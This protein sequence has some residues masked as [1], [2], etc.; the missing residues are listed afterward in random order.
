MVTALNAYRNEYAKRIFHLKR[1]DFDR[2]EKLCDV[3]EGNSELVVRGVTG[4]ENNLL[5]V[6]ILLK[7]RDRLYFIQSTTFAEGRK[8]EANY[9]L[10]DQIVQEFAGED[11]SLDFEGSSIPGIAHFYRNFGS[12]NQPY[13]F[14]RFNHLPLM[15]RWMKD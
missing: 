15:I 4:G 7:K 2:F 10:V 9:Y 14:Y 8:V 5:A 11:F 13:F 12:I 1:A 3:A 6:S